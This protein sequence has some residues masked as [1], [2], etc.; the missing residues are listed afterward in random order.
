LG[1]AVICIGAAIWIVL[2]AGLPD[3]SRLNALTSTDPRGTPIA[4]EVGALAPPI[5]ALDLDGAQFSLV[6]LRGSPVIVNFW[7]TWCGPCI[8]ETPIIQTAYEAHRAEGLR[9][10]GVDSDEPSADVMAWR[11]RFGLSFDLAIDHDGAVSRQYRVRGLPSTYF[12]GR[13]GII[14]QIVYG[15]LSAS[16]LESALTDLLR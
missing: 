14:R 11:V 8:A 4:P 1:A 12:V 7:A 10:I 13:D 6:A 9:V 16:G 5:E 3:R 15:P 2:A